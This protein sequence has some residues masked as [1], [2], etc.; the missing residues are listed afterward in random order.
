MLVEEFIKNYGPT[1][2]VVTALIIYALGRINAYNDRKRSLRP[3]LKTDAINAN[4]MLSNLT[5]KDHTKL[6]ITDHYE[7][8][9]DKLKRLG[10]DK[11]QRFIKSTYLGYMQ[12]KNLG[13]GLILEANVEM[14]MSTKEMTWNTKLKLPIL[15][16]GEEIYVSTDNLDAFKEVYF[17]DEIT[18]TYKTQQ[19]ETIKYVF[20]AT[21]DEK[22]P[23]INKVS[24][25]FYRK[26]L[27]RF[28]QLHES[29]GDQM[30]WIYLKGEE[31]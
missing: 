29:T 10:V 16:V 8:I 22:N 30:E 3:Y 27:F 28:K 11:D 17:V 15:E 25:V 1:F 23:E 6:I 9:M 14:H 24:E 2:T 20:R 13:P 26:T 18:I 5:L 7:P 12:I 31:K 4:Y 21:Q 19:N